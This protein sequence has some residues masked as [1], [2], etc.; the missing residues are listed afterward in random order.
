M[1]IQ[2]NS[3]VYSIITLNDLRIATGD[4]D[5]YITLF[6]IKNSGQKAKNIK[7]IT[8]LLLLFVN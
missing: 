7:D 4:L 8:E 2:H 1:K 3:H 6:E 5:G